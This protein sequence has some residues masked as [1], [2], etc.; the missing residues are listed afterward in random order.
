[1]PFDLQYRYFDQSLQRLILD[2]THG[3]IETERSYPHL[4]F[5]SPKSTIR[6]KLVALV[7]AL[8]AALA[9]SGAVGATAFVRNRCNF[10]IF[11]KTN[12]GG[13]TVELA[14]NTGTYSQPLTG[15]GRIISSGRTEQLPNPIQFDFSVSGGFT[16]YDVS[17]IGGDPFYS[18]GESLIP[19]DGSCRQIH[20]AA[21]VPNCQDAWTP[22]GNKPV[23]ACN[24]NADLTFYPC[25][26]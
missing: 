23:F 18:F 5:K 1:M 25:R 21:N 8:I 7:S 3:L 15:E 11:V 26:P 6:M 16:Y 19:S 14:A 4:K 24:S 20:C 2:N 22:T 9:P 12:S 13:S 17:I 10:P